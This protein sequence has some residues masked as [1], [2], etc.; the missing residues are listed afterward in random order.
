MEDRV[1]PRIDVLKMDIEGAEALIFP[2][3]AQPEDLL[4]KVRFLGLEIHEEKEV[5]RADP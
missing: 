3:D 5:P 1:L 4:S 2:R